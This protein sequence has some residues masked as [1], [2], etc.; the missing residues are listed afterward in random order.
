[1][2]LGLSL[3]SLSSRMLPLLIIFLYVNKT[4]TDEYVAEFLY[5]ISWVS[6]LS[7]LIEYGHTNSVVVF[8]NNYGNEIST[9][10]LKAKFKNFF[11]FA[12]TVLVFI[13]LLNFDNVNLIV[14]ITLYFLTFHIQNHFLIMIRLEKSF[15]GEASASFLTNIIFLVLFFALSNFLTIVMSMLGARLLSYIPIIGYIINTGRNHKRQNLFSNSHY[16]EFYSVSASYWLLQCVGLLLLNIDVIILKNILDLEDYK[17]YALIMRFYIPLTM[18]SVAINPVI[19]N[20]ITNSNDLGKDRKQLLGIFFLVIL[21]FS[22]IL[23]LF[24]DFLTFFVPD[25]STFIYNNHVLLVAIMF[26]RVIA[27]FLNV[28]LYTKQNNLLKIIPS[29]CAII[30]YVVYISVGFI[31]SVTEALFALMLM[32]VIATFCSYFLLHGSKCSK[33]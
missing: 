16:R 15:Q 2:K 26:M 30:F 33:R 14:P 31:V 8:Y 32:Y 21:F 11:Y 23:F 9:Y 7:T 3:V 29:F 12:F 27:L 18:I 22:N 1:M 5:I 6:I 24:D 13:T 19:M 20:I 17:N 28:F 10:A 25:A 4:S